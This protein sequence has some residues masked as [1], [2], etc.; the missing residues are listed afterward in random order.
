MHYNPLEDP[1]EWHLA[2]PGSYI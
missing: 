2:C 1:T